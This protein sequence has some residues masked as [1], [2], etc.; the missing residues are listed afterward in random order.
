M[1]EFK[2][3]E[4]EKNL[5]LLDNFSAR[6]RLYDKEK[7]IFIN[8]IFPFR[9]ELENNLL[10]ETNEVQTYLIR[11]YVYKL[12]QL[13]KHFSLSCEFLFYGSP[14][15][16]SQ[17]AYIYTFSDGTSRA[18]NKYEIYLYKSHWV[19]IFLI[20]ELQR[21]CIINEID[22]AKICT[23]LTLSHFYINQ[24]I[25]KD[26]F[27]DDILLEFPFNDNEVA[28]ES[29]TKLE[30]NKKKLPKPIKTFPEYFRH[31]KP[32]ALAAAIK[33]AFTKDKPIILVILIHSLRN[34]FE[35]P[36]L[37]IDSSEFSDFH[38]SMTEYFAGQKIG[39]RQFYI[40]DIDTIHKS[41]TNV[42]LNC[43]TRI[44]AILKS[45]DK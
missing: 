13:Q 22:F 34:E 23:D 10:G 14:V 27:S 7:D 16:Y 4:L 32:E 40:K 20:N 30:T 24:H 29:Q 15:K 42:I 21:Y 8:I 26:I 37:I 33:A 3:E 31:E 19:F 6:E 45:I 11:T 2:L 43:K 17:T 18:L 5:V 1:K 38:K 35:K 25:T 39:K 9:H 36:L 28:Q 12:G 44:N 41:Y